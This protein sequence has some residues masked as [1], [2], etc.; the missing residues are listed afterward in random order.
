MPVTNKLCVTNN[1]YGKSFLCWQKTLWNVSFLAIEHPDTNE[2]A[3]SLFWIVTVDSRWFCISYLALKSVIVAWNKLP[4]LGKGTL[5][6]I[7]KVMTLLLSLSFAYWY[8]WLAW[9]IYWTVF[10]VR[11]GLDR[12]CILYLGEKTWKKPATAF[13]TYLELRHLPGL[14][15]SF[16]HQIKQS[17]WGRRE[18]HSCWRGDAK[19]KVLSMA[20][21]KNHQE[22]LPLSM[23]SYGLRT[24][25]NKRIWTI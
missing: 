5:V 15:S 8:L 3:R 12:T 20:A 17:A 9:P 13:L 2:D 16:I 7:H 1:I 11:A 6:L 23:K 25:L 18:M 10:K 4:V 21:K 24:I 22:R 14:R 19:D